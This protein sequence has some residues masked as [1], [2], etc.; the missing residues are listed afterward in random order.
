MN[1][2]NDSSEN[3]QERARWQTIAAD[4]LL[5]GTGIPTCPDWGDEVLAP[6]VDIP[7]KRGI[8][9][10]ARTVV[11]TWAARIVHGARIIP[12]TNHKMWRT[13]MRKL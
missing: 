12:S 13:H 8:E 3:E 7:C 2:K 1:S 6:G 5:S 4:F 9:C 10:L 11:L